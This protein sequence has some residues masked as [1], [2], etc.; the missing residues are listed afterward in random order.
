MRSPLHAVDGPGW[1]S[2]RGDA[3]PT[4][5]RFRSRP[6]GVWNHPTWRETLMH[7]SSRWSG[8]LIVVL[9]T[10]VALMAVRDDWRLPTS[11]A[12]IASDTIPSQ[13][14]PRLSAPL[15]ATPGAQLRT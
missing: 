10:S 5:G 2:T 14:R 7:S 13:P 11:P 9:S 6:D 15:A 4:Q 12:V 8:L 1:G 3:S